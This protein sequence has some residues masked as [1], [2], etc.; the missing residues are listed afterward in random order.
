MRTFTGTRPAPPAEY[1][2]KGITNGGQGPDY[3]GVIGGEAP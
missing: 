2:D 3:E 1:E